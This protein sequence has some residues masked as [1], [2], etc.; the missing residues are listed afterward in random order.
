M[1]VLYELRKATISTKISQS[2]N[3]FYLPVLIASAV[4]FHSKLHD[5]P[6]VHKQQKHVFNLKYI[7]KNSG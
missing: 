7:G 6:C 2:S 4:R 3:L 1:F 5:R